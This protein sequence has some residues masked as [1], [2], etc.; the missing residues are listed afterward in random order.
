MIWRRATGLNK[1]HEGRSKCVPAV[2]APAASAAETI[3]R[4]S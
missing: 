1:H 2:A 4:A 3:F